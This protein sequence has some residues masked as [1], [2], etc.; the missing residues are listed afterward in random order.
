MTPIAQP[1]R[2]G[3]TRYL[4]HR[5]WRYPL[6]AAGLAVLL[7]LPRV[8][9]PPVALDIVCWALFAVAVD[10]LL[11]YGGLLS[12]GHA[13][14]WGGSAYATGL[15]AAHTGAPFPVAVVAGALVAAVLAAPIGY[16]AV[17]RTGIY[18]AMVTLAF[19]Q[20]VYFVANQ[21]RGL[22]GGENGLQDV[23][24]TL[25]GVDLSDPYYF[26]YWMLPLV[27]LGFLAAW[28]IVHSPF[29]RVLV[30]IR[31]NPVRAR[32]LGYPVHRYKVAA[33]VLS[34]ALAG[35]AGGLFAMSHQFVT[36]DALH[37]TTSGQAVVMVVLGG[38]GTLW[39]GTVAAA[40][41]VRLQ[42]I[43][44]LSHFEEVGL[45]TGGIFVVV[46]LVFRRGI[47]GTAAA[48]LRRRGIG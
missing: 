12:F 41:L 5:R 45:I 27:L 7:V 23:P 8:L 47:W 16:L 9:Y 43:L 2:A 39:G 24:R 33:F 4:G 31:D 19:A 13:A 18:F 11:G 28:R 42:D 21:W 37:W 6:L 29:G 20:L 22:T 25:F 1:R 14:F 17:R 35:L 44:S 46:V 32:S 48:L 10:L 30:A 36:L 3:W 38:I 34:A 40:L 15:V 26:Y